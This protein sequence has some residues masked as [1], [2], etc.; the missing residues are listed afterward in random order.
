MPRVCR[1]VV[2]IGRDGR[3]G[4]HIGT[5]YRFASLRKPLQSAHEINTEKPGPMRRPSTW[6]ELDRLTRIVRAA[7]SL[8]D[9]LAAWTGHG[10]AVE[11]VRRV[12]RVFPDPA[13]AD[14]L[15]LHEGARVQE[16]DVQMRCGEL[17]VA[18]ARSWVAVDSAALTP[19]VCQQLRTGGA[20]GDALRPVQRRRVP[21]R[22]TPHRTLPGTDPTQPVLTVHARLDVAGTP[23]A[24]CEETIYE[25]V[26]A[27]DAGRR[28][29]PLSDRLRPF[30]VGA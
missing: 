29:A 18:D 22:L 7:D 4:V 12:D 9:T 2:A 26:F 11:I 13:V 23:V 10:I 6:P 5:R 1:A 20:L 24:W 17:L 3:A 25:A 27:R 8:V 19:R 28:P 16:R 30:L 21:V 14:E 15:A